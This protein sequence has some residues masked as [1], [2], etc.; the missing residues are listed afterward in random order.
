[1]VVQWEPFALNKSWGAFSG[2]PSHTPPLPLRLEDHLSNFLRN[3]CKIDVSVFMAIDKFHSGD[4]AFEL[5]KKA[6]I[7]SG[8]WNHSYWY[9]YHIS[10]H[11]LLLVT[12]T[13]V[14]GFIYI[15]CVLLCCKER[16]V[17][18]NK[19]KTRNTR[20]NTGKSGSS[21]ESSAE[22]CLSLYMALAVTSPT[23]TRDKVC[24]QKPLLWQSQGDGPSLS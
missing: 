5:C 1:M 19:T 3:F 8:F 11:T 7:L 6:F 16:S 21:E 13:N 14:W 24:S 2:T 15:L 12:R 17:V 23:H 22:G 9:L 18:C 20:Q 10:R 4:L